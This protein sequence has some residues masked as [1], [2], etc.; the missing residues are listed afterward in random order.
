MEAPPSP[1]PWRGRT[2]S[3]ESW[4]TSYTSN[5]TADGPSS[6]DSP[7]SLWHGSGESGVGGGEPEVDRRCQT[8]G[9]NGLG[10]EGAGGGRAVGNGISG[11]SS[12]GVRETGGVERNFGAKDKDKNTKHSTT[13]GSRLLHACG[14]VGV[15]EG[16]GN[17]CYG[18]TAYYR[19]HVNS[20]NS[21]NA[22][23]IH[24]GRG[25]G[26]PGGNNRRVTPPRVP[27]PGAFPRQR[28]SYG[29][30][31]EVRTI[32]HKAPL[33]QPNADANT[34][35]CAGG[36]STTAAEVPTPVEES[37]P[38]DK[39]D[40]GKMA[41]GGGE[42]GGQSR[43]DSETR[44]SE[45]VREQDPANER[46]GELRGMKAG[47]AVAS[48]SKDE[49]GALDEGAPSSGSVEDFA[50]DNPAAKTITMA[51]TTSTI[52]NDETTGSTSANKT[53]VPAAVVVSAPPQKAEDTR[54]S[55]CIICPTVRT[56]RPTR[57]AVRRW[58]H[59]FL[60]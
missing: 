20:A 24:I 15:E 47:R 18:F 17:G 27:P 55:P 36:E 42:R 1:K 38:S 4:R 41:P 8:H 23:T 48:A 25:N 3:I 31:I 53:S 40:G 43:K 45:S 33:P 26:N 12:A 50:V 2:W 7:V 30:K 44:D 60:P 28:S 11:G 13:G 9:V 5:L 16:I 14:D 52:R 49:T 51:T 29:R 21:N 19:D 22:P 57:E 58:R 46:G 10:G 6:Q 56:N 54:P 37:N 34:S 35:T 39:V 32:D 59:L